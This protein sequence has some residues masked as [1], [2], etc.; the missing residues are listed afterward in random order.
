MTTAPDAAS[1]GREDSKSTIARMG[2]PRP[3]EAKVDPLG[4]QMLREDEPLSGTAAMAMAGCVAGLL[5]LPTL[6]SFFVADD[7]VSLYS[8]TTTPPWR[9]L[10][11]NWL[12]AVGEGGFY[13]PVF[14]WV[15]GI[16]YL[17]M[18]LNPVPFRLMLIALFSVNAALVAKVAWRATNST[19]AALVAGLFFAAHPVHV[20]AIGWIS[21]LL[22]Q[23]CALFFLLTV[24]SFDG[25]ARRFG[26]LPTRGWLALATGL[27]ALSLGSKEMGIT[28][29][30]V[31]IVWDLCLY[32]SWD[33]NPWKAPTVLWRAIRSR[34]GLWLPMAALGIAYLAFRW[35]IL[36]GIGGYGAEKHFR[37]GVMDNYLVHYIYFLL[38][39]LPAAWLDRAAGGKALT[40]VLGA[41]AGTAALWRASGLPRTKG[42]PLGIAWMAITWLPVSTLL[43]TQY[44]F[45]PS[46]GLAIIVGSLMGALLGRARKTG[47]TALSS[48]LALAM[49]CWM[50]QAG[51]SLLGGLKKWEEGGQITHSVLTQTKE[52][53]GAAPAA[54]TLLFEGLPVNIGVPVFQHG[55]AESLRLYLGRD[56]ISAARLPSFQQLPPSIDPMKSRFFRY[57][58]GQLT[59]VTAEIRG[60]RASSTNQPKE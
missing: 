49:L 22:E 57:R 35:A 47:A 3:L 59:E 7:F 32:A 52:I 33:A 53:L 1:L 4:Q 27:M 29:P 34:I 41:L 55:I 60:R 6:L 5:A 17:P 16:C 19:V 43:R 37:F 10:Y 56:E 50:L 25:A 38:Q 23:L 45:L 40:V 51:N 36:G 28:L 26:R 13:R 39:P 11:S 44:M 30:A 2:T 46:V 8:V 58:R 20:E 31:V 21:A 18:G 42:I 12:G 54:K 15:L 14:N 9:Y 24:L 48:L